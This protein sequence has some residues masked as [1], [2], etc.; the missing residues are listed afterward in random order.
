MSPLRVRRRE[1]R[2]AP[3]A[4][5]P[6]RDRAPAIERRSR[7]STRCA[8]PRRSPSARSMLD[9]RVRTVTGRGQWLASPSA[10]RRPRAPRA[11]V[12]A[13]SCGAR[14]FSWPSSGGCCRNVP[15]KRVEG[16][17]RRPRR[18]ATVPTYAAPTGAPS[19]SNV[20]VANPRRT[21]ASYVLSAPLRNRDSRVARPSTS[22]STPLAAGSSVPVCPIRRSRRA[23]RARAT[24]SW[25]LGPAGLSTT[26][27]P[28]I[29]GPTPRAGLRSCRNPELQLDGAG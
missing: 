3:G 8:A 10:A 1:A 22:G 7:P 5:P 25:E 18:P 9:G 12:P 4:Q 15:S 28:S 20:V 2:C 11:R 29:T 19:A 26:S 27:R 24:T 17:A 14:R 23:R 6:D 16:A 13:R 21:S